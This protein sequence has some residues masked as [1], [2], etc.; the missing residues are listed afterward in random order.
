MTHSEPYEPG[1]ARG[2]Q[3]RKEGEKWMLILV[4][5]LRHPPEKVWQAIT[6]PAHLRE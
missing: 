1:P 2:A 3:V 4:R 5:D 6:D